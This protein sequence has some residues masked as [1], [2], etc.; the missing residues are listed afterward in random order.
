MSGKEQGVA[1]SGFLTISKAASA[2]PRLIAGKRHIFRPPER[3]NGVPTK[4]IC[5]CPLIG[6]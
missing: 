2:V 4:G 5:S 6:L 1:I 3:D